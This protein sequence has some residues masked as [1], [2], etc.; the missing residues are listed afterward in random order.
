M[1]TKWIEN[2]FP[3]ANPDKVYHEEGS[4]LIADQLLIF[5]K[6]FGKLIIEK[7]SGRHRRQRTKVYGNP[8]CAVISRRY[9]TSTQFVIR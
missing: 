7:H 2:H 5:G 4:A 6:K 9:R 3:E 1:S 8:A